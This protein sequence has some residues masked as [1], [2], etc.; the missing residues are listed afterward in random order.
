VGLDPHLMTS[1]WVHRG[2]Q[3]K[4]QRYGI[5]GHTCDF[6]DQTSTSLIGDT[7]YNAT[8]H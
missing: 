5:L 7:S 1:I 3:Q 4:R 8:A 6:P 2:A